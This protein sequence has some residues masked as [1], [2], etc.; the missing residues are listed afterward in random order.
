[1]EQLKNTGDKLFNDTKYEDANKYYT[2]AL[3]LDSEDKYKIYLNR[4]LSYYKQKKYK[5]A[6]SDA[7]NSTKLKP[8]N[9]KSWGRLGSCLYVLDKHSQSIIAFKKAYE[10]EP[11]NDNYKKEAHKKTHTIDLDTDTD[12]E[13]DKNDIHC[14]NIQLQDIKYIKK[15]I[16][17]DETVDNII[18]NMLSNEVLINKISDENFQNKILSYQS[19]PFEI[20]KDKETMSLMF[21]ILKDFSEIK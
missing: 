1:M 8:D 20:L 10:L 17:N 15:N 3:E 19:N 5:E 9:A 13:D 2:Q 12:D 7:I 18:N 6:L 16:I 14:D 21:S 11:S 4:C